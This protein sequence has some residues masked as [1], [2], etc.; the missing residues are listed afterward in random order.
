MRNDHLPAPDFVVLRAIARAAY[1][2]AGFAGHDVAVLYDRPQDC[3]VVRLDV[4]SDRHVMGWEDRDTILRDPAAW[5]ANEARL[6]RDAVDCRR[7]ASPGEVDA[8]LF[9]PTG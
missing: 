3:L 1:D 5:F 8:I 9:K 4:K 7:L 6:A 2:A